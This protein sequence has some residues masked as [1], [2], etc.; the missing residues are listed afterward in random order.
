[1]AIAHEMRPPPSF[2]P[3]SPALRA[4][5]S[6]PPSTTANTR[7]HHSDLFAQAKQRTKHT[8]YN[9]YLCNE[10]KAPQIINALFRISPGR[11]TVETK[12][13]RVVGRVFP[14]GVRGF[15]GIPFALP[16]VEKLRF[17]PPVP[18]ASW[19]GEKLR[20]LEFGA[21]CMQSIEGN[22]SESCHH[23]SLAFVCYEC[24]YAH[25]GGQGGVVSA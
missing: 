5:P 25:M 22:P 12:L 24:M 21:E 9:I 20:A 19:G 15:L 7:Y 17:E 1:M 11:V 8:N 18:V 4:T 14:G 10:T 13:G 16:P 2:H 23:Q 6:S 3:H